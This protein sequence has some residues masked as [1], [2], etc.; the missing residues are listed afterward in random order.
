MPLVSVIASNF[1]HCIDLVRAH[2][3]DRYLATLFAPEAHRDALYALYAFNVEI[4]R[5]REAAREP[6]PG[7]IRLQWWRE[8]V[9]GERESEAAA[10]P[11]SSALL[12]ATG[13]WPGAAPSPGSNVVS[14]NRPS[15]SVTA[16]ADTPAVS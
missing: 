13:Y 8:A 2:D 14:E 6:M 11:V 15:A 7:E 1:R 10:H 4:A 5:V 16:K 12:T 3:R 9:S